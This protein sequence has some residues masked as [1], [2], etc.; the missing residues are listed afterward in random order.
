MTSRLLSSR[1]N[2]NSNPFHIYYDIN[3]F[4]D[5]STGNSSSVPVKFTETRNQPILQNP[6]EYFMSVINQN[7]TCSMTYIILKE[8]LENNEDVI[9]ETRRKKEE[10][11][12]EW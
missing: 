11:N 5:D 10:I 7:Y 3:M 6:S 9:E 2:Y 8:D 4:N 1:T 12:P